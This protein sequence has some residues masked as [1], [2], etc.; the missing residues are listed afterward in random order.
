MCEKRSS[1]ARES[2]LSKTLYSSK[3]S[4]IPRVFKHCSVVLHDLS[5]PLSCTASLGGI[6]Q[7][8]EG[9]GSQDHSFWAPSEPV[10]GTQ[11]VSDPCNDGAGTGQR[12]WSFP[13]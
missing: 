13:A 2:G 9:R 12:Q 7:Q 11:E 10:H 3:R 1:Q 8:Q 6:G 5:R 4:P